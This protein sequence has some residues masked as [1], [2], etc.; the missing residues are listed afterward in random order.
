[1]SIWVD[2]D[3]CPKVI[4][5]III[6]AA[7][8]TQTEC[9]LVANHFIPTPS[10]VF[11]KSMQVSSGFDVADNTIVEKAQAKDLV[12]TSDIPLADELVEKNVVVINA[13]GE[14]LTKE[15]VR[16]RLNLRDF[17]ETMRSS[18][19]QSGGPSAMSESDKRAFANQLDKYLAQ[20]KSK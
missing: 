5:E 3:G 10:S 9:T 14:L 16:Q 7:I 19:I 11:I 8:R 13:R 17:Y 15:N 4:R 6:K 2:A 18:G 1:M 20:N 12:I